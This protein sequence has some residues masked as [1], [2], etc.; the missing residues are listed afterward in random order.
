MPPHRTR[1]F[2]PPPDYLMDRPIWPLR[3]LKGV[4]T[5]ILNTLEDLC[6]DTS[7]F[8][9]I[10]I[11][12]LLMVIAAIELFRLDQADSLL[13]VFSGLIK[14]GLVADCS[15]IVTFHLRRLSA[16]NTILSFLLCNA[17]LIS[18]SFVELAFT[19]VV[20][21]GD[22]PTMANRFLAGSVYAKPLVM[23][24]FCLI[25]H[26]LRT[27]FSG[28]EPRTVESSIIPWVLGVSGVLVLVSAPRIESNRQWVSQGVPLFL[29]LHVAFSYYFGTWKAARYKLRVEDSPAST[30]RNSRLVKNREWVVLLL[31][32]GALKAGAVVL[33]YNLL[34]HAHTLSL[35]S[36]PRNA[37]IENDSFVGF[38]LLPLAVAAV[39]H[40]VDIKTACK[41]DI[42]WSWANLT[43]SMLQTYFFLRPL[44][45]LTG[46][47]IN[48]TQGRMGIGFC[49]LAVAVWLSVPGIP[50]F[51]KGLALLLA[52]LYISFAYITRLETFA[53]SVL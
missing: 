48:P 6:Q 19:M 11:L 29:L 5:T 26:G 43:Q 49:L 33:V 38:V 17:P 1:Y 22:T 30:Q 36:S 9:R 39:D 23:G 18:G 27:G 8:H 51:I 24:G 34:G 31:C 45:A 50:R 13:S 32:L 15:S 37:L 10:L 14:V 25:L 7:P 47:N 20:L 21:R 12:Q 3:T 52:Y 2:S 40:W 53:R 46:H 4:I 41:G 44:T 42:D 28:A 16:S 35:G